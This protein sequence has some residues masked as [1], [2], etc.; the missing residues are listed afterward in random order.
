MCVQTAL[1][2]SCGSGK[3]NLQFPEQTPD[4]DS[5]Y[6]CRK[7]RGLHRGC[8]HFLLSVLDAKILRSDRTKSSLRS[9]EYGLH[10]NNL[11]YGVRSYHRYQIGSDLHQ[12]SERPGFGKKC[13]QGQDSEIPVLQKVQSMRRSTDALH[14]PDRTS[15]HLGRSESPVLFQDGSV[16]HLHRNLRGR[17][18]RSGADSIPS[19]RGRKNREKDI[20]AFRKIE[21]KYPGTNC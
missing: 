18:D 7:W 14:P 2:D 20:S 4:S 15:A 6:E 17:R 12:D 13:L 8:C 5:F 16:D 1:S 10:K 19:P 3:D 11:V 9:L 21:Y